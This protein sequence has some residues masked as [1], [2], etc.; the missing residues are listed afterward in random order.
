MH[1]FHVSA[2]SKA[3]FLYQFQS[4]INKVVGMIFATSGLISEP[5]TWYDKIKQSCRNQWPSV[6][7]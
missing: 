4:Q 5:V 2:Y 3:W 6:D 1:I 7:V